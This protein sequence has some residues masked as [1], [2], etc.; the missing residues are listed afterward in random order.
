M[1]SER[2]SHSR[3][4]TR[5]FHLA[6]TKMQ[7]QEAACEHPHKCACTRV[8]KCSTIR[9]SFFLSTVRFHTS[10]IFLVTCGH[11]VHLSFFDSF[12][13]AK[14][15]TS[16]DLVATQSFEPQG[17]RDTSLKSCKGYRD[18]DFFCGG[19][20]FL[21]RENGFDHSHGLFQPS[22]ALQC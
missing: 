18:K 15:A 3:E 21:E 6:L 7:A 4:K 13:F 20:D 5:L 1:D 17:F 16:F 11:P 19:I 14:Q 22:R 2:K 12:V 10:L 9:R 8:D